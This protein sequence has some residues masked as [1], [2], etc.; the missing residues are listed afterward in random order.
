MTGE[1]REP[2]PVDIHVGRRL[3]L[4]RKLLKMSQ[5][6]L[7]KKLGVSY[8]QIQKYEAGSNRM[9]ASSI[10][11]VA[12]VLDVKPGWFFDGLDIVVAP[13]DEPD[14][15]DEVM[16]FISSAPGVDLNRS[17]IRISSLPLRRRLIALITQLS[18]E[19]EEKTAENQSNVDRHAIC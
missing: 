13:E 9:S 16:S 4:R 3:C 19:F 5:S 11:A 2:N 6:D 8:Q 17:F 14:E 1:T 7:G 10:A 12:N 18:Q 15:P